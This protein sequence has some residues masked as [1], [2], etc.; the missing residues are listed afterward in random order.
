MSSSISSPIL[1][2]IYNNTYPYSHIKINKPF[3]LND[4]SNER[5]RLT[6][7]FRNSGVYHFNQD[8]IEFEND[9]TGR[10]NKMNTK[11]IIQDRIIKNEKAKAFKKQVQTEIKKN[12][13]L[14]QQQIKIVN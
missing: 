14:K 4:F 1:D 3:N 7:L 10:N 12:E 13:A 6:A 11:L 5:E 8:Y 9:T 2:S